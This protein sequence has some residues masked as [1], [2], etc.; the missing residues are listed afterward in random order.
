MNQEPKAMFLTPALCRGAR[1]L[2]DWTQA[3]LAEKA[4]VS[5]ST[6]RDFEAGR[7]ELHRATALQIRHS[8][9]DAGVRFVAIDGEGTGLFLAEPGPAR[10]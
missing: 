7:H 5:R 9:E 4:L 1:G 10:P 2:L 3:G 6:I 8:M